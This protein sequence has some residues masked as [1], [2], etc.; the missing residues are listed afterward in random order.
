MKLNLFFSVCIHNP[1]THINTDT[2]LLKKLGAFCIRV[3]DLAGKKQ[4]VRIMSEKQ[5]SFAPPNEQ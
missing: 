2:H 4:L 1:D 3:F 5:I